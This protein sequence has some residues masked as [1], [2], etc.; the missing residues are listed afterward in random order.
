MDFLVTATHY[1]SFGFWIF[2]S[3]FCEHRLITSNQEF[4][5]ILWKATQ[6]KEEVAQK[7]SSCSLLSKLAAHHILVNQNHK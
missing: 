4:R 5:Q 1:S 3:Y 7:L 2:F 6:G